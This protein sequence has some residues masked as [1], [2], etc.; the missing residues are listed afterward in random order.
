LLR[1]RTL[2]R[3]CAALQR[4]PLSPARDSAFKEVENLLGAFHLFR[5]RELASH[6]SRKNKNAARVGHPGLYAMRRGWG[7]QNS[8]P[9]GKRLSDRIEHG[10]CGDLFCP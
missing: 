5:K 6:P 1:N 8:I 3:P 7:I 9:F 4:S 2:N 10:I